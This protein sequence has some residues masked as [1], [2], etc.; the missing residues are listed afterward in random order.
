MK[1]GLA[2]I[3]I[4]SA[5]YFPRVTL[6]YKFSLSAILVYVLP[7]CDPSMPNVILLTFF[8]E[9]Y[10]WQYAC[11]S[12]HVYAAEVLSNSQWVG[13]F[14]SYMYMSLFE[15]HVA[16]NF[17]IDSNFQNLAIRDCTPN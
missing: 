17:G 6:I 7:L 9:L 5:L 12:V 10:D 15:Y 14:L 11:I 1:R 8:L 3:S 2:C 4:F 13:L 16:G